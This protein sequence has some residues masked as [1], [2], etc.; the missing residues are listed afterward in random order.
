MRDA[1]FS[2][3]AYLAPFARVVERDVPVGEDV[4]AVVARHTVEGLSAALGQNDRFGLP[5]GRQIFRA[6]VSSGADDVLAGFDDGVEG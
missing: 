4:G 1:Q 6:G 2:E 5:D 3:E